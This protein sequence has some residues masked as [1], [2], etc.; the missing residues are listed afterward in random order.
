MTRELTVIFIISIA[1]IV[2]VVDLLLLTNK[3]KGDTISEV[4]RGWGRK[5]IGVGLLISF[6]MGLLAGHWFW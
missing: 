1:T 3:Q 5:W 4:V 6:A 2:A